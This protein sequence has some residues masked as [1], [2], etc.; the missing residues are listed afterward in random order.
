[1]LTA[2][3]IEQQITYWLLYDLKKSEESGVL[4]ALF[5]SLLLQQ[6]QQQTLAL[7]L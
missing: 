5:E 1:M 7:S 3:K 6:Q 2:T 4:G